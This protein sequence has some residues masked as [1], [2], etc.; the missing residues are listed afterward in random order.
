MLL[1][2]SHRELAMALRTTSTFC[3]ASL[4]ACL[5]LPWD[6]EASDY[7]VVYTFQCAGSGQCDPGPAVTGPGGHVFVL[8][9]GRQGSSTAA[10]YEFEGQ[11]ATV[12][13][14]FDSWS[15]GLLTE[16]GGVLYGVTGRR[17]EQIWAWDA[18]RGYR[19][20]FTLSSGG[21]Y[22]LVA[23]DDGTLYFLESVVAQTGSLDRYDPRTGEMSA[24]HTFPKDPLGF[25]TWSGLILHGSRLY[26]TTSLGPWV[27]EMGEGTRFA[28]YKLADAQG[29]D[30]ASIGFANGAFFGTHGVYSTSGYRGFYQFDATHGFQPFETT[31]PYVPAGAKGFMNL[32]RDGKLYGVL[33]MTSGSCVDGAPGGLIY[34]LD[35]VT[36][37]QA[38]LHDW[39]SDDDPT[40]G[41]VTALDGALYGTVKSNPGY[42]YRLVP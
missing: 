35:P 22:R 7:R 41:P 27:I 23:S 3:L 30:W 9:T 8:T 39:C 11:A 25:L 14:S 20:V 15:A 40:G 36:H 19:T 34:Q 21:V 28:Q 5:A 42:I 26:G 17:S 32:A 13:H 6:A 29:N 10:L 24:L 16:A 1:G 37:A 4:A 12:V 33:D 31:L 2:A 18:S 38:D